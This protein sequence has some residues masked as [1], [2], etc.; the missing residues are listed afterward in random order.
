M[1]GCPSRRPDRP[2]R[3]RNAATLN[4]PSAEIF[5]LEVDLSYAAN[6]WLDVFAKVG[7]TD[8]EFVED[9]D[10]NP[11]DGLAIGDDPFDILSGEQL[12]YTPELSYNIGAQAY[13][14]VGS[15]NITARFDYSHIGDFINNVETQDELDGYERLD[16]RLGYERD[17]W[18]VTAFVDNA[19]NEIPV[20]AVSGLEGTSIGVP[21]VFGVTLGVNY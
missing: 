4:G 18:S 3:C 1:A 5:G 17:N 14:P 13:W 10:T 16:L 2:S 11:F 8:A 15:G 12:A 21:R 20:L 19:T 6:D 9:N 7:Y